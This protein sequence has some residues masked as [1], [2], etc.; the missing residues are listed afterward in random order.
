MKLSSLKHN[1]PKTLD[2]LFENDDLGLFSDISPS[3]KLTISSPLENNFLEII[4]FVEK[5]HRQPSNE[6]ELKEKSLARKLDAI[7]KNVDYCKELA[8][9]DRFG[10][11]SIQEK[12]PENLEEIFLDDT[13]GLLDINDSS[14]LDL[15]HIT[16]KA[17][18]S[19]YEG[20]LIGER[21]E[22]Q[23]FER[24]KLIFQYLH[25]LIGTS[26]IQTDKQ[27][28][29]NI[30]PGEIFILQGLLCIVIDKQ[31]EQRQSSRKNS[32]LRIIFEN[33]TESNMLS[34][35]LYKALLKDEMSKK[36]MFKRQEE[37][38][39]YFADL[40]GKKTGYI[41]VVKLKT[42]KSELAHFKNLYKIGFTSGTIEERLKNS[43]NDIAFLESQV[44]AV[45]SFECYS[46]NP[47]KLEIL[48]HEFLHA[49]KI[50]L[51]LISKNGLM[52]QPKEWFDVPLNTVEQ[53]IEKLIDGSIGEYRINNITSSL[54]KR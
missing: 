28:S 29:E 19:G 20:E 10:L 46:L 47:H 54:I 40:F 22:C 50:Q 48:L 41:Y 52:Y 34:R 49:Q 14:I 45:M 11:L 15:V 3:K 23:D 42:P 8:K 9:F 26:Y 1:I 32:R 7:R 36:I 16:P 27:K 53:V 12:K 25:S 6:G 24:Y 37:A 33:G 13:L 30:K 51:S 44:Q 31:E 39:R 18:V 38:D 4:D 35:S 21:K 2:E 5:Y 43:E 17:K